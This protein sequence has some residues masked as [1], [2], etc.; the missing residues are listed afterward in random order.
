M[1]IMKRCVSRADKGQEGRRAAWS[2]LIPCTDFL[3]LTQP[4]LCSI[5]ISIFVE[6]CDAPQSVQKTLTSEK[7]EQ[8]KVMQTQH[9][10]C[11]HSQTHLFPQLTLRLRLAGPH[12]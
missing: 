8:I 6:P 2:C 4:F 9:K 3:E 1:R 12:P 10:L 5:Q 7:L 11:P